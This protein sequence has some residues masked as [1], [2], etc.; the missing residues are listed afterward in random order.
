MTYYGAALNPQ[1][2]IEQVLVTVRP[3]AQSTQVFTGKV[4]RTQ[5]EA[6]ADILVANGCTKSP[7]GAAL[8]RALTAKRGG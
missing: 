1:G 5:R 3:P 7:D 6:Q 8:Y 2:Q 4:Y